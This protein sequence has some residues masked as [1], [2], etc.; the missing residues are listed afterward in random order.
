MAFRVLGPDDPA[1]IA[2]D[3]ALQAHPEWSTAL[4]IVPWAEY[5]DKLMETL[6]APTAPYEAVCVPGHIWIPELA[7]AGHLAPFDPVFDRLPELVSGYQPDEILPSVA[8][9]CRYEGSQYMLPLFTD[10]HL[11]FYRSDEVAVPATDGVPLISPTA[12]AG[13]AAGAHRPE[14]RFG[15]ALKAD[16]SEI[17]TDWL[18][19]LWAEGGDILDDSGR[20][21]FAGAAG[22]RALETYCNLRRYC[23]PDT[24]TYGNNEIAGAIRQGRVALA[25]SWG[26]QAA[27][28]MSAPDVAQAYGVATYPQPW[29]ATWGIA[30]PANQ[31]PS[32]QEGI[33]SVLLQAAGPETD[34]AVTRVAGSPVRESSYVP[35]ELER[36][37]WLAAQYEMLKRAK[38]LPMHPKVGAFL[39]ALYVAVHDAFVGKAT[40]REALTRAES[41]VREVLGEM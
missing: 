13:L 22:I 20:P 41:T 5:R 40:P 23:P 19:Y 25:A 39:G 26:G 30:L 24:H 6:T 34:R 11:I 10:G 38:T 16:A 36:Y 35:S 3:S 33:L 7:A 1:L 31:A 15:L 9:E 29:N 32:V 28:I 21:V 2:L 37:P 4:T 8:R 14:G 12:V 27:A 17:L 18:P